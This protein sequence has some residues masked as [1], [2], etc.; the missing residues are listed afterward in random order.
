MHRPGRL[1]SFRYTR[2]RDVACI[3]TSMCLVG[4]SPDGRQGMLKIQDVRLTASEEIVLLSALSNHREEL[5]KLIDGLEQAGMTDR[6]T[7]WRNRLDGLNSL[8][9]KLSNAVS[10]TVRVAVEADE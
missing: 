9:P 5:S 3:C 2:I 7:Y 6:V 1:L 8:Y 4:T 10:I